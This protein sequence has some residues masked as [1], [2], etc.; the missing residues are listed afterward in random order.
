MREQLKGEKAKIV[1]HLDLAI[2]HDIKMFLIGCKK[3]K[4]LDQVFWPLHALLKIKVQI[5]A[6][7]RDPNGGGGDL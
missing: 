2:I 1:S 7:P 5:M 6:K 4:T 3:W